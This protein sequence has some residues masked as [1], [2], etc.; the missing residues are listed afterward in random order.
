MS[1]SQRATRG[2]ERPIPPPREYLL[3]AEQDQRARVAAPASAVVEPPV[4][5]LPAPLQRLHL[6]AEAQPQLEEAQGSA[7]VA[8]VSL[9]AGIDAE[10]AR[11]RLDAAGGSIRSAVSA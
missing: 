6:W 5:R 8:I 1:P 7:K 4:D 11:E 9:L 2:D 3:R 10:A